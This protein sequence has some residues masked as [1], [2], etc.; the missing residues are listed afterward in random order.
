M[1]IAIKK[2]NDLIW[3]DQSDEPWGDYAEW[4][5][6]ERNTTWPPLY[7]ESKNVE[8]MKIESW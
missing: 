8:L 1:I 3:M 4:N 7:V 5:E 6:S 2:G